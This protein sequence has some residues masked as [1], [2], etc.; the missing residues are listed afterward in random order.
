MCVVAPSAYAQ[1]RDKGAR[2]LT[3]PFGRKAELRCNMF[4]PDGYLI[5]IGQAT[6]MLKRTFADQQAGSTSYRGAPE[7]QLRDAV[8][9]DPGNAP[10][11]SY[12]CRPAAVIAFALAS[13]PTGR[14]RLGPVV[15]CP[16]SRRQTREISSPTLGMPQ[17]LLENS[18]RH[19]W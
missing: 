17:R 15:H 10:R 4:D 13:V 8:R 7:L 9:N 16:G 19:R 6:G 5:E 3:G 11:G 14:P 18:P 12:G 1:A 2:F